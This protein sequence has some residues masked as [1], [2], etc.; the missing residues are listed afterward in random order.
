MSKSSL[1]DDKSPSRKVSPQSLKFSTQK[2]TNHGGLQRPHPF[3][4]LPSELGCELLR[5]QEPHMKRF[6]GGWGGESKGHHHGSSLCGAAETNLT[7]R[8]QV[9][10]LALLSGLRILHCPELWRRPA[11][12]SP[13]GPLAWEPPYAVDVALKRQKKKS[14]LSCIE[15]LLWDTHP[16]LGASTYNR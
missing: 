10:S 12:A 4:C 2:I 1:Q 13:I 11:A 9:Q 7:M 8:T 5:R 16:V 6:L 15:S 3:P 14:T